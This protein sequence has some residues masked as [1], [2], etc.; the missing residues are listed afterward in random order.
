MITLLVLLRSCQSI[1]IYV[2]V[3]V[4]WLQIHEKVIP[5]SVAKM[6]AV[7]GQRNVRVRLLN[8]E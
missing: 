4:H 3:C 8:H 7:P 2:R 5:G 6:F 1:N